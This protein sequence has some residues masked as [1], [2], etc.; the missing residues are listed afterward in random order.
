MVAFV[1]SFIVALILAAIPAA[2]SFKRPV[3]H[4]TTW[5]EGMGGAVYTMF[6]FFWAMVIVPNSWLS[7]AQDTWK[8]TSDRI[9]LGPHNGFAHPPFTVTR[10]TV[11]DI[12]ITM[13]YGFFLTLLVVDWIFWQSRGKR[14]K[15]ETT[16][17]T[18]SFGPPAAKRMTVRR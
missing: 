11:T 10:A 15:S 16:V 6:T 3:D 17:R 13:I 12:V 8:W 18:S 9:L 14:Q 4:P 7:L 2:Y 5:G 1:G